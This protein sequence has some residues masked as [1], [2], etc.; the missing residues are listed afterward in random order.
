MDYL[1]H[2]STHSA[3]TK[4]TLTTKLTSLL[5]HILSSTHVSHASGGGS[6]AAGG[7]QP[8]VVVSEA[9]RKE[10]EQEVEEKIAK[11]LES[12]H[13]AGDTPYQYTLPTYP[14]NTPY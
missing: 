2:M 9:V 11:I 1:R 5:T 7:V 6:Y 4:T 13:S 12:A 14:I 10:I 8:P 3:L